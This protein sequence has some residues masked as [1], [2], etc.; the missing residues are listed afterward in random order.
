MNIILLKK[1][2]LG[3][4][5]LKGDVR[6]S[7]IRE[8]LRSKEGDVL[9]AGLLQG[10]F[11]ELTLESIDSEKISYSYRELSQ[12]PPPLYPLTLIIGIPRPP[13]ARRLIK[14]LTTLGVGRLI[15]TGTDLNEKSY[16]TSK[17]WTKES[18]KDALI[19][20]AQQGGTTQIPEVE[21]FYSLKKSLE[22]LED[23]SRGL[24]LE[25]NREFPLLDQWLNGNPGGAG[26]LALGPERGWTE[27]E[28][29]MLKEWG[30]QGISLGERILRTETAALCGTSQI[31]QRIQGSP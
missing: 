14:D 16:L 3:N 28:I 24:F 5:L 18:Y 30:F 8:I 21:K 12:T 31:I 2:E 26:T 23:S 19:E 29:A 22:S 11:L 13:T 6:F 27:R 10:P 1:E 9:K 20:G 15:F 17:L 25:G 7:H 4:P